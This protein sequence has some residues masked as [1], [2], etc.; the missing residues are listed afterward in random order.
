MANS[1]SSIHWVDSKE[2]LGHSW[3]HTEILISADTAQAM[4][5]DPTDSFNLKEAFVRGGNLFA[6]HP[7]W[8]FWAGQRYYRRW[9]VDEIDWYMQDMSGYG[10]RGRRRPA[11]WTGKDRLRVLRRCH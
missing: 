11:V 9:N 4:I 6:S 1:S 7:D 2:P 10:G 8:K 3:F 5:P